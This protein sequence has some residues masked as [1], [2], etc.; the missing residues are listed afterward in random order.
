MKVS[1]PFRFLLLWLGFWAGMRVTDVWRRAVTERSEMAVDVGRERRVGSPSR[2]RRRLSGDAGA[3]L[4]ASEQAASQS[5]SRAGVYPK[6]DIAAGVMRARQEVQGPYPP[7]EM[8]LVPT[9]FP[10]IASRAFSQDRNAVIPVARLE[11]VALPPPIRNRLAGSGWL[12]VRAGGGEAHVPA[13]QLGGSQAGLRLTYPLDGAQRV[14][15]SARVST[16]LAGP[17]REIALGI[18]WQPTH[19]PI[20]VL[21]EERIAIDGA[22]SGPMVGLV[23]GFGPMPVRRDLMVEGYGQTGVVARRD[24]GFFADGAIR[25]AH[26]LGAIRGIAIDAGAGIWGG[27]QPGAERFDLG[28]TIG[29][30]L[31]CEPRIRVAVDWRQRVAGR[32]R[33]GSG[34]ALSLGSGW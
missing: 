20:H 9:P 24:V 34:P 15:V 30:D 10:A 31:P 7:D 8:T 3:S 14:A 11:M 23:G 5:H 18:D 33:P 32:S 26:P 19:A 1:R 16:P 25:A 12:I 21:A 6:P 2:K 13:S 17:G 29:L 22:A 28:P 27:V 4:A